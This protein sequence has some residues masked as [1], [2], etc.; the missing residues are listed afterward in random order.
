MARC[1][2]ISIVNNFCTIFRFAGHA[3]VRSHVFL[4]RHENQSCRHPRLSSLNRCMMSTEDFVSKFPVGSSAKI[5]DRSL[6]SA[7][8]MATR[9]CWPP[10]PLCWAC[11][12]AVAEANFLQNF[13]GAPRNLSL[14]N[15]V[16]TVE[17][18]HGNVVQSRR[19]R[20]QVEGWN[21]KPPCRCE[22]QPARYR[23]CPW[24]PRRQ[25]CTRRWTRG[26]EA[27]EVHARGF[28]RCPTAR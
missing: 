27:Y 24:C 16:L 2:L 7:R 22:C 4:V 12:P 23:S 9:C 13:R 15:L 3:R 21:T 10:G 18:W 6:T 20:E 25:K 17:H 11:G 19:A 5:T 26:Q 1:A 28:C 14:R 8:A